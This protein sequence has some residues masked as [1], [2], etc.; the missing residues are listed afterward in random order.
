MKYIFE[1]IHVYINSREISIPCWFAKEN[2]VWNLD[3]V[4]LTRKCNV[5]T[6][7]NVTA[8]KANEIA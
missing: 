5:R 2:L 4:T 3:Y 8:D 7:E 1:E 6:F